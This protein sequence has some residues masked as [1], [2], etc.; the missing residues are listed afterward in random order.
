VSESETQQVISPELLAILV[1]PIDKQELRL[2][3]SSLICTVCNRSYPIEDGIPNMLV[4]E[5]A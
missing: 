5:D 2:D 3:G 1:C 4:D